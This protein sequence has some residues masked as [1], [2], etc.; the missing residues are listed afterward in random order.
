[1]ISVSLHDADR[2]IAINGG[3]FLGEFKYAARFYILLTARVR[4]LLEKSLGYGMLFSGNIDQGANHPVGI[5]AI[6]FVCYVNG[7]FCINPKVCNEIGILG[8]NEASSY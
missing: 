3:Q 1:M 5:I 4:D 7:A 8:G 2:L 6:R